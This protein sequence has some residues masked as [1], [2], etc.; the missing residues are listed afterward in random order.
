MSDKPYL[1]IMKVECVYNPSY[2]DDRICKC[3]HAYYRHFDTY[4]E[5]SN[6]GCKYCGCH[7]FEEMTEYDKKVIYNRV[8][9]SYNNA[10]ENGHDM[11]AKDVW[12]IVW[13]MK[14]CDADL[15]I[16]DHR[17]LYKMVEDHRVSRTK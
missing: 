10:I 15:E 13:D 6:V 1:K 3:S 11:N 16:Y 9:E 4:E 14:E 7:N 8:V 17:F 2:G 5:M 12:D